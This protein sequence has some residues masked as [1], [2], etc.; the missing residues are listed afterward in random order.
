MMLQF[1][2]DEEELPAMLT[3]K[4]DAMHLLDSWEVH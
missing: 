1:S 3:M 4:R 2:F